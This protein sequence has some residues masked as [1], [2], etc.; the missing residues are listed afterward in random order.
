MWSIVW[1][2]SIKEGTEKGKGRD[3]GYALAA[4]SCEGVDRVETCT[5]TALDAI[6]AFAVTDP[7]Y[8][9]AEQSVFSGQ[10]AHR[11]APACGSPSLLW[12]G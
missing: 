12:T 9:L 10:F 11:V 1:E 4:N 5:I 2:N 3:L 7:G 6:T 8:I